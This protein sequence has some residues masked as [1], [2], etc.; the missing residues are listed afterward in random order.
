MRPYAIITFCKPSMFNTAQTSLLCLN[1]NTI[2][3]CGQIKPSYIPDYMPFLRPI[4]PYSPP[5]PL[6]FYLTIDNLTLNL[7][8]NLAEKNV[9]KNHTFFLGNLLSLMVKVYMLCVLEIVQ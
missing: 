4:D 8:S 2:F 3:K 7:Q 1:N 9:K 5:Y 6:H